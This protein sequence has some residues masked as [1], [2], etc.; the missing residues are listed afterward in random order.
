MGEG[1]GKID[2]MALTLA[3]GKEACLIAVDMAIMV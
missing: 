2:A 1:M 3:L